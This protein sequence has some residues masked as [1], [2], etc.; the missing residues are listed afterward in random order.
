MSHTSSESLGRITTETIRQR[1][2]QGERISCLTAYDYPTARIIDEADIDVILVGDSLANTV[3][4]YEHTLPVTLE[5]MI[6]HAKAVRR[7]VKHALLVGDM[8]FGSYHTSLDQGRESAIRYVKEA[9]VEAVKVEGGVKRADL[10]RALVDIEI[11]VLGHIGLTPQSYLQMGGYKVQGKTVGAAQALIADAMALESAGAFAIVLE[12]IPLEIARLITEKVGIPTIGIGAGVGCDGQILVVNDL[13]GL[14]FGKRAK[15]V[16]EYVD[17]KSVMTSAVKQYKTDVEN[18]DFPNDSESYH[19][20]DEIAS[21][22]RKARMGRI[23]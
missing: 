21:K 15:F 9:G 12:G 4:G 2:G 14:S 11:P 23:A 6:H 17:L 7:A 5:E 16:R 10:V 3:L 18:G 19:L 13:L 20:S 1:K 22:L 8:P